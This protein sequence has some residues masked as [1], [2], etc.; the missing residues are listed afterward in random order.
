MVGQLR[1]KL[2]H[3]LTSK[4]L[5]EPLCIKQYIFFGIKVINKKINYMIRKYKLH[6]NCSYTIT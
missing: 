2:T 3:T 1:L 5:N 4:L 6:T